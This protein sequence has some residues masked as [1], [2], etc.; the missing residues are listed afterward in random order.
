M[1]NEIQ[2]LLNGITDERLKTRLSNAIGELR[3]TKKFGLVFEEH[4][5]ELLPIYSAPIRSQ[6]RVARKDGCITDTYIVQ[7]ISKG[8]ATVKPEQG[9]GEPQSMP[10]V[11]L[12]VIKRFGE[13]IFPALR[14]VESVLHGG[15]APHH[16]LIEADNY[17]ALQLLEWLYAG[18]VDCIYI[19]PPYNTGARDWKYNNDYVD[20]SDSW[21]HSKWLSF[22]KKRFRLA[23]RLLKP[24]TGVLIVTIDEHEVSHL[25]LLLEA[26][27]PDYYRQMVTIVNNPKGVTQGRF[28]RVE[29]Y[30]FFCF[31]NGAR[32]FGGDDDLL[33]LS[34]QKGSRKPRWKGL[35]R[36]G[37]NARRADRKN[38]FFPVLVDVDKV[39]VVDAGDP[40]PFEQQPKF[41]KLR[42]GLVPVWPVRSDLSLGNW[43]VGHTTLRTLIK[44]G[45][46][47]LGQFDKERN[48]FGISYLSKRPQKQI[49]TGELVIV[50][51]DKIRNVV[52]VEYRESTERQ[53]KS[54]WH[55]TVHD[56][57]AYGSDL[58]RQIIGEG[59]KFPFPKS[60]YAVRDAV[61][62]IVRNNKNA[63][64]LDFFAGSGTTLHATQVLNAEDGGQ[65]RCIIVTNNA[66]SEEDDVRLRTTGHSPGDKVWESNGICQSVTFPRCKFVIN[67]KRDDGTQLAGEYLTGR[68]E[69]Q[70]VRRAIRPLDF[71]TVDTL[72]SK[73][74][75]EAL[76]VAVD[77]TKSKVTGEES[78]LLDEGEKV[79]VLLEQTELT[80]FIE[81]GEEWAESIETVYLPFPSGRAFNQAKAMIAESWP[82]LTKTVEIRR[83][84][85]EGLV[86]NLDYFRL[87]FM[88][89]S[90]VETGGKLADLL[91][92]LWMMAGCRGK[93]PTCTGKEDM[94]FPRDCSFTV[95]VQE[96]AFKSFLDELEK[97]P[98]IDWVFLITNDQDGF[99]RMAQRLPEHIPTNQ[100]VHLWRNYLDNFL[101]NVDRDAQ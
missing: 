50:N 46:V 61:A 91:P 80:E 34:Q 35:L 3:K 63:L 96:Y 26:E 85:K 9:D 36:S 37:T 13:A 29:E 18:T 101:I 56:A 64:I 21:K 7:R 66:V 51:H 38:M 43:G 58:L 1:A 6:I 88:D 12:V 5:P 24:G 89:R 97:R 71:A 44:K 70:E 67:G 45:Y 4:L 100:R 74:A 59:R 40:L 8:V 23:R 78:F 30:A 62:C 39:A 16:T 32:V 84:I 54:V 41:G 76:A 72:S 11:D 95:L 81:E 86:S 22:M 77:F 99:S 68:F 57:G 31:P 2:E 10:L 52:Q 90:H 82:P 83:P 19:D 28:S 98:N 65:R 25:G 14:R 92:A 15:D 53:T 17:H 27:L 79:A 93:V 20:K 49:E 33:S 47:A 48:T 69:E 73:K 60:L 42:N 55:R 75:R 94:L 87:D